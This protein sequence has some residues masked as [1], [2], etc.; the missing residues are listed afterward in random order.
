MSVPRLFPLM[1]ALLALAAPA[2]ADSPTDAA[3][4][5]YGVYATFHPSDGIPGQAGLAKYVPYISPALEKLLVE[6]EAAEARFAKANK[7]SPP[8]IEG[9]LFSSMFEGATSTSIGTC[10]EQAAKAS[11]IVEQTYN[12]GKDAP[13]HWSDTVYLAKT[14]SDW[15]VDDIVYGASWDFANKGSLTATLHQAIADAGAD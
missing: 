10:K 4:V 13:T 15:R 9:D 7:D 6:A 5:F 1:T 11:C 12:D 14:G 8:L 3:K 2:L